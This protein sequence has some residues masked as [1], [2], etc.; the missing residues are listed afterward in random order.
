METGGAQK[1]VVTSENHRV[2]L[3]SE[4]VETFLNGDSLRYGLVHSLEHMT[5]KNVKTK[6]SG[7]EVNGRIMTIAMR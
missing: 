2:P 3:V 4:D 1:K 5:I 6:G 7:G